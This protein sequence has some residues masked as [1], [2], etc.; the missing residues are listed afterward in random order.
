MKQKLNIDY[1]LFSENATFGLVICF[2]AF[3]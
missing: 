2:G 1:L 3:F